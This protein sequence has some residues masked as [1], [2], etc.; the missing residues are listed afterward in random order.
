MIDPVTGWFEIVQYNDKQAATIENLVD[1]TWLCRY[2]RLKI[3]IYVRVNELLGRVFKNYLIEK[4]C[5]IKAKFD[6]TENPQ[7]N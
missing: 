2:P 4:E 7:E 3:I 6:N 5:G 1:Q